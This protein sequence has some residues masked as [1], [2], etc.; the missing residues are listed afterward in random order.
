MIDVRIIDAVKPTSRLSYFVFA[1]PSTRWTH[2]SSS[3]FPKER[4]IV[5][6]CVPP[7]R[8]ITILST[9]SSQNAPSPA[10]GGYNRIKLRDDSCIKVR[11]VN[12]LNFCFKLSTLSEDRRGT[13]RGPK[14]VGTLRNEVIVTCA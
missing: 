5:S 13:F 8:F 1:H 4:N 3:L 12:S 6:E 7:L 2:S 9:F 10:S 11:R 14:S